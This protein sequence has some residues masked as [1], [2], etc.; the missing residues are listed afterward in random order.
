MSDR[1]SVLKERISYDDK[2]KNDF[3]WAKRKINSLTGNT[4]TKSNDRDYNRK[5]SNYK[6]YNNELDVNDF[7]YECSLLNINTD[8]FNDIIQPYIWVYNVIN[9]LIGENDA[10]PFNHRAILVNEEGVSSYTNRLKGLQKEYLL[11]IIQREVNIVKAEFMKKN[12][13]QTTGDDKQDQQILQEYEKA[14]QEQVA[15]TSEE[16]G[17]LDPEGI[18]KHMSGWQDEREILCNKLLSYYKRY[19]NLK[20]LKS[21]SFKHGQISGEEFAWVGNELGEPIIKVLNPLN[22]IYHKSP[23]VRFIQD[24]EYAGYKEYITV[25]DVLNRY[26]DYMTDEQIEQLESLY[27]GAGGNYGMDVPMMGKELNYRNENFETRFNNSMHLGDGDLIGSYGEGNDGELIE[28][29]HL[30]WVSQ[31]L[32]WFIEFPDEFGETQL[33]FLSEE[34]KIPEEATKEIETDKN[35]IKTTYYYFEHPEKGLVKAY[36]KWIPEVWEGTK[37]NMN[38]FIN[39]GP[40]E[41]QYRSYSNPFKVELGYK[42]LVY[43]NMNAMSVSTMDRM[44]PFQY[45]YLIVAHKMKQMIALDK[46]PVLNVDV[47][48]L[49]DNIDKKEFL[50]FMDTAGI[51]FTQRLKHVDN[52][53]AANLMATTKGGVE[54][55]STLQFVVNY[56]T[57]LNLLKQDIMMSAGVN[58][59]RLAQTG[60]QQ[61]VTGM[62]Q[63]IQQSA[64]IT[65]Y[66]FKLHNLHW[67]KIL[68]SLVDSSLNYHKRNNLDIRKR[69]ILDDGSFTN[70]MMDINKFENADIGIFVSDSGK[71]HDIFEHLRGLTQALIQ[72]DK[73]NLSVLKQ[74][75]AAESLEELDK[76]IET[77]EANQ[78]EREQQ[79]QQMQQ[80]HEAKMQEREIESREDQ[81]AHEIQLKS[82]DI[83]AKIYDSQMDALKFAEG[84]S[85]EAIHGFVDKE[86]ERLTKYQIEQEN[87]QVLMSE[88]AQDRALK[89]QELQSKERIAKEKEAAALEREKIKAKTALKNKVSGE[90]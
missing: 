53:Q 86:Q 73:I 60:S 88:N 90:K 83:E 59:E 55:R 40:K 21:D 38:I 10:R 1:L 77:F 54:D 43:N 41:E 36:K 78:V 23:E 62:Q 22:V 16:N 79:M 26:S 61:S 70:L 52:P 8:E 28:V 29:M 20:S 69:F 33:D 39:I 2:I 49:P 4:Y 65:D 32:V 80:E 66:Y 57:V 13:P 82:M 19:L 89:Q 87:R 18:K 25:S 81:Q 12:P 34:F 5:L 72:N 48:E 47:D 56:Y 46:P 67:S 58:P 6:L 3:E 64:H 68:N 74:M 84:V 24:G 44:K 17:I 14:M 27:N 51:K 31:K 75:L 45:L 35:K 42:G 15:K 85:P 11:S 76:H 7:K 71:E 30:E 37:I 9:V 63:N 50:H